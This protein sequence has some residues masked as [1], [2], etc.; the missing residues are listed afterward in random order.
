MRYGA[1]IVTGLLIL[2]FG[3]TVQA[4]ELISYQGRLT[5][6]TGNPVV[7]GVYTLAFSLWD[8]STAGNQQWTETQ[9]VDIMDGLFSVNLGKDGLLDASI[10]ETEPLFLQIQIDE[11]EII[12]PRTR[13][14]SAPSAV[15]AK[16]VDGDVETGEGYLNLK[17][18]DSMLAV[19]ISTEGKGGP[20]FVRMYNPNPAFMEQTLVQLSSEV[21]GGSFSL[22]PQGDYSNYPVYK[23]GFDPSPFNPAYMA[24]YDPSGSFPHDPYVKMGTVPSPFRGYLEFYDAGSGWI[25]DP[26][27]RMGTQPSPFHTGFI[28]MYNPEI[29]SAPKLMEMRVDDSTGEWGSRFSM[30]LTE[31]LDKNILE[32]RAFPSTGASFSMFNPQ[33]EPPAV[34]FNVSANAESGPSMGF[35][36]DIGQVMG[37]EPSPFNEGFSIKLMDPGDDGELLEIAGNHVNNSASI[38]M[39]TPVPEPPRTL[40]EVSTSAADGPNMYL[41]T[42]VPEPPPKVI[43]MSVEETAGPS[44]EWAGFI[45]M[46]S[47]DPGDDGVKNF[48]ISNM[49]SAGANLKIFNAQPGKASTT[50]VDMYYDSTTGGGTVKC[51]SDHNDSWGLFTGRDL[52][53]GDAYATNIYINYGG[54][55]YFGGYMGIGAFPLNNILEIQQSS[56][57]DPIADAWTIYSSQRWKKNIRPIEGALDKVG[58]LRGVSFDW[59]SDDKHDIGMVAEEVGEII[60]EVVTYEENGIDAR[61]VDYN[62]LTAVLVEAIKE[63]KSE[64]EELK[65]RIEELEL[66]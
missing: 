7:D 65:K 64:N 50:V 28:A 35:Y 26:M 40:F 16:K 52:S 4:G 17:S 22:F 33:M 10:F 48:E 53:M 49:A 21:D 23:L 25:N 18:S 58:K 38:R 63:L 13:L 31:P 47:M 56:P 14:T 1:I 57:T 54:G 60:P 39:A 61:S 42:P 6:D 8:D 29:G 44:A 41:A 5:D 30:Y 62:R 27:V 19:S 55:S 11:G 36:D 46:Y 20:S 3:L 43:E 24:F 12:E 34:Y 59:I 51:Y 9:A 66:Q 15:K 45:N 2:S 37:T 32:M